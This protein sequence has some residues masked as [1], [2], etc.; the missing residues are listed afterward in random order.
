M[1]NRF[2][3]QWWFPMG[4][5][6]VFNDTLIG[7]KNHYARYPGYPFDSVTKYSLYINI[8]YYVEYLD[9]YTMPK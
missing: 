4:S 9:K 3:Q 6:L 8:A 5:S 7:I 2:F 1:Q